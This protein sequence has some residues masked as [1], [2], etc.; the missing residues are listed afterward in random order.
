ME[1]RPVAGCLGARGL[2]VQLIQQV[3]QLGGI[4]KGSRLVLATVSNHSTLVDH[5]DGA[6][7][8]TT[9]GVPKVVRL[10]HLA[11]G[12]PIGELGEGDASQGSSP[13]T[14]GVYV[15]AANA[16]H[17]GTLLLDPGVV[18]PEQGCLLRSTGGEVEHM[19]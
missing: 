10:G 15:V 5:Q 2:P 7:P 16:Q 4:R 19:E 13:C 8:H 1:T 17:L 12:V 6:A 18:K 14:V 3:E 9:V 11:M